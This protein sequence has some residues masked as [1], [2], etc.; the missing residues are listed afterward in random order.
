MHVTIGRYRP[1]GAPSEQKKAKSYADVRADMEA[2]GICTECSGT[3]AAWGSMCS[4]CMGTGDLF[5]CHEP[6][7]DR[8]D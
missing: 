8:H 1:V 4:Y 5:F 2:R 6:A 3:G 7:I